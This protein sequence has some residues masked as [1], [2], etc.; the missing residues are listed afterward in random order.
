MTRLGSGAVAVGR[1]A[2]PLVLALDVGTS[3]CRAGLFDGVGRRVAVRPGQLPTPVDLTTD[4]GAEVDADR[5]VATV[6][7]T[8]DGLL[9]RPDLAGRSIEVVALCTFWHGLLGIDDGAQAVTPVYFW[10]DG[11]ARDDARALQERL[12]ERA[13]HARTGC[14]L[15]ATYW[16]AKLRWLHRTR[17][18]L[19]RRVR[20]WVSFGDYLLIRQFGRAATS[21]SM[22][23]GTGLLDQHTLTWDE[24]LLREL[25]LDPD[26]L[27]AIDRGPE[28][29]TS[30]R[31]ELACRWPALRAAAWLPAI[32][33]GAASNLG[34]GCVTRDRL[35]LMIGTS[36]AL[37]ALWR[38]ER[39]AIPWGAWAYRA[40]AGRV[41]L[42]GALN[43]G[44]SLFAWLRRS[45]RLPGRRAAEA[46]VAALAPDSH[47]L[48]VLPYWGGERSPRWAPDARGA[49]VGLRLE[50]TPIE[51]LRAALEAVALRFAC[52]EAILR[53]IV[54]E[55]REVVATGGALLGSPAWLQILA[56]A[57]GRPIRASTEPEASSRG[58]ALLALETL[59][60]LSV[61]IEAQPA[62]S[63]RVY[64]PVPEHTQRYREA[65]AR[66][67]QLYERLVAP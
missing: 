21:V 5:L 22:A 1:A 23:S 29:L 67:S 55:A 15:H 12:D 54:P 42:G 3:S 65:T 24:E 66:Q 49:V 62:P 39:F 31:A 16:P 60:R 17:P 33:D 25:S 52:L 64:E 56:D 27:P 37:R 51:I 57:L 43:D 26:R 63:G 48:T 61:P 40:D 18:A 46:A 34:A 14:V 38:A 11:R 4:G 2:S 36:G 9:G 8:I 6:T 10:L 32:G 13:V 45:F 20:R 59:G 53:P 44:G 41:V 58:A 47:G 7:A 35:A 30:L 50:T 28:P 19:A